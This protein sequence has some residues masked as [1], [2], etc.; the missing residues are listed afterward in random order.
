ME[1]DFIFIIG[2]TKA[3]ADETCLSFSRDKCSKH[4]AE[5]SLD[6]IAPSL[7]QKSTEE[8]EE[9]RKHTTGGAGHRTQKPHV[10]M[11]GNLSEVQPRA[12]PSSLQGLGG[13]GDTQ[14]EMPRKSQEILELSVPPSKTLPSVAP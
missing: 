6:Q 1:V 3:P 13:G 12:A 11:Q 2:V 4:L 8:E 10:C 7:G 9:G 5:S 14:P